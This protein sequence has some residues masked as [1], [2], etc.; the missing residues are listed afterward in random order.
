MAGGRP[1]AFESVEALEEAVE[2]YFERGGEAWTDIGEGEYTFTPTMAGLALALGVDRKT[3]TN[4]GNKQ[5]YFPTIKKARQRV[6][7]HLE[8][9]LYGNN[10][11]G[12]I[13]NLK[14]NFGW[15]DKQEVVSTN[16]DMTH[17]EWLDSLK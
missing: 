4:Y 10:V 2:S 8:K 5:E 7:T 14:N 12:V 6:E 1:L 11:T 13:F 15:A 16:V 9:R 3:I 17:E